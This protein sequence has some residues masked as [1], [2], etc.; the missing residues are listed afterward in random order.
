MR[1]SF[2]VMHTLFSSWQGV[3]KLLSAATSSKQQRLNFIRDYKFSNG[4]REK[5]AKAHPALSAAEQ[6]LV[7]TALGDYFRVCLLARKSMA[8]MPSQIVDEAWH[9]F[10]LFT[11]NYHDFCL[12]AFG[13][14]LHHT[15]AQAMKSQTSAQESIR[16]TWR[17]ACHQAGINP[18]RP[19]RLPLLFAIDGLLKIPNGFTY[20][21]DCMSQS[22]SDYCATHIGCATGCGGSSNG[23]SSND[24]DGSE[25]SD[26]GASSCGGSSCG[27]G[28]GGD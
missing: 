27:G 9:E 18:T 14:F 28:C 7:F 4:L 1:N 16:R 23:S 11:Q 15:P 10:I 3:R 26:S 5:F 12:Q 17:L 19:D 13:R 25:G 24:C 20:S 6:E 8:A 21:L 22:R 2:T